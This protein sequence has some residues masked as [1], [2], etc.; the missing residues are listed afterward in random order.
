[1][2]PRAVLV[3]ALET[4]AVF[5]L[6]AWAH[7]ALV[8]GFRPDLLDHMLAWWMPVRRDTF[9]IAGFAVSALCSLVLDHRG[10]LP[11]SAAPGDR[12]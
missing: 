8:A 9:G 3:A 1:M 12:G 10:D 6:L 2:T 7:T 5:G 11:W 4:G